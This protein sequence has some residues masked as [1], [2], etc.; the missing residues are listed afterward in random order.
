M[1]NEVVERYGVMASALVVVIQ[2]KLDTSP[3]PNSA[4]RGESNLMLHEKRQSLSSFDGPF[5]VS[6]SSKSKH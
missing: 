2:A 5:V 4:R 3:H 6:S 1:I